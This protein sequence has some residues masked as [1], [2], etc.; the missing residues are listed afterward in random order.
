[1]KGFGSLGKSTPKHEGLDKLVAPSGLSGTVTGSFCPACKGGYDPVLGHVCLGGSIPPRKPLAFE[2]DSVY[3]CPA[4]KRNYDPYRRHE[5][6]TAECGKTDIPP[7]PGGTK[8]SNPKDVIGDTKLPLW[9]LSAVAKAHWA[10]AQF[11]GMLKYG[12]WNWREAGVRYS[13]YLSAMLRHIDGIA[14]GETVDPI[15]GTDHLGNIMACAAIILDARAAGKLIDDRP[16][17]VDHR[18]VYKELEALMAK[19]RVQY[20]DR[21][22]TH[23]TIGGPTG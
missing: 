6:V 4:C 7:A 11:A 18:P 21:N 12:A 23:H 17:C 10:L 19:L 16:P 14:S 3:V 9:L 20:A 13:V 8:A 15:D 5:C 22:P 2:V 1:M